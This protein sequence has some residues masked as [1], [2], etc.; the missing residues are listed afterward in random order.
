M[1]PIKGIRT[2]FPKTLRLCILLRQPSL[3]RGQNEADKVVYADIGDTTT[4]YAEV[5]PGA[6]TSSEV[7]G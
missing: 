1:F 7:I 2:P 5:D 3:C 6:A 4:Q